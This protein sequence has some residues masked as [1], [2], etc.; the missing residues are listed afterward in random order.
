M[1]QWGSSRCCLETKNS[2]DQKPLF[3]C[4]EITLPYSAEKKANGPSHRCTFRTIRIP[5][6]NC[7]L[8][9]VEFAAVRTGNF[10]WVQCFFPKKGTLKQKGSTPLPMIIWQCPKSEAVYQYQKRATDSK[11]ELV[12]Y[13][14]IIWLTWNGKQ[15]SELDRPALVTWCSFNYLA[16]GHHPKMMEI[17]CGNSCIL[18]DLY[19]LLY[20]SN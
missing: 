9:L 11:R 15:D 2:R 12:A 17:S 4:N 8:K 14:C 1:Y 3:K 19:S 13:M 10:N 18:W 20:L 6:H 7:L 16:D 5:L